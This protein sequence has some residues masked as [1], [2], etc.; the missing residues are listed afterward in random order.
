[1]G[2]SETNNI[3]KY[4]GFP[5]KHQGVPRNP[6][7]FIVERVM[8]K[9]AGWK[10]KFLSFASWAVLIKSVMSAVPNYIMQGAVLPAYVCEK[11]DKINWDFLWGS[12]NEKRRMHM[13]IWSKIVKSKDEGGLGIQEDR[14]KNIALISKLNWR[15]YC[16]WNGVAGSSP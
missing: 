11:L 9:L 15:M 4:L 3:G 2:V 1:M 16:P 14:A 13:V 6:Y 5:L 7:K 12:T 10:A 8:N